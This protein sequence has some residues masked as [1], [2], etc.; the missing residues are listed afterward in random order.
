MQSCMHVYVFA[1]NN[2]TNITF[3][4]KLLITLGRD[5]LLLTF[6]IMRDF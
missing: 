2:A 6:Y 4:L 5:N 1:R 3:N